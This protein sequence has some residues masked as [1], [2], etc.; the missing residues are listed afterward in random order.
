MLDLKIV[1]GV[2]GK[3]EKSVIIKAIQA[4]QN[5]KKKKTGRE[6]LKSLHCR[7]KIIKRVIIKKKTLMDIS[8][9]VFSFLLWCAWIAFVIKKIKSIYI[10]R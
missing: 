10:Q 8:F 5:R 7:G 3:H 6:I 2:T 4:L 9:F 1:L